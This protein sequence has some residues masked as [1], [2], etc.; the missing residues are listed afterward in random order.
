MMSLSRFGA[1]GTL[2]AV[3]VHRSVA[4][5][6][7]IEFGRHRVSAVMATERTRHRRFIA[8]SF[9]AHTVHEAFNG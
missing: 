2:V 3:P 4:K 7:E 5:C 8:G 1:R 9:P 6:R